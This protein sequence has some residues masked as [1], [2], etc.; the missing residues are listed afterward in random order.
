MYILIL[1]GLILGTILGKLYK[2]PILI[3]VYV[4]A[5]VSML[6]RS[7]LEHLDLTVLLIELSVFGVCIQIGYFA[8]ALSRQIPGSHWRWFSKAVAVATDKHQ[9]Q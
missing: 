7:R 9:P 1:L 5:T 8:G 2:F 3:P 6:V 4:L